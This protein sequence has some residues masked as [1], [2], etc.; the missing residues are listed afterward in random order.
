[1]VPQPESGTGAGTGPGPGMTRRD[2]ETWI[3]KVHLQLRPWGPLPWWISSVSDI[4]MIPLKS[5]AAMLSRT[6]EETLHRARWGKR[7]K[8]SGA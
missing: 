5:R 7:S 4:E 3:P 6:A 8:T 1:V 2:S